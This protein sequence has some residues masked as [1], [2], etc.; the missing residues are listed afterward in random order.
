M[1]VKPRAHLG[2]LFAPQHQSYIYRPYALL[3]LS[4]KLNLV[5]KSATQMPAGRCLVNLRESAAHLLPLWHG[6]QP[7]AA[8]T[9]F[10]PLAWT[11]STRPPHLFSFWQGLIVHARLQPGVVELAK[12][13]LKHEDNR[14]ACQLV[15]ERC[16]V[17]EPAGVEEVAPVAPALASERGA[18]LRRRAMQPTPVS[19]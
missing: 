5:L 7:C 11:H 6:P 1:F 9:P 13:A 2:L 14:P 3:V 8:A 19:S 18:R 15:L 4:N 10:P 12:L 16:R 17:G